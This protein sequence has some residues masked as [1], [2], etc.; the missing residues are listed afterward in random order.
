[1]DK[2]LPC[3]GYSTMAVSAGAS[4]AVADL[5][6]QITIDN[7]TGNL[8]SEFTTDGIQLACSNGSGQLLIIAT[9]TGYSAVSSNNGLTWT[10]STAAMPSVN[11]AAVT[12]D[13]ANYIAVESFGSSGGTAG[14]YSSSDGLTWT[15][16]GSIALES[17]NSVAAVGSVLVIGTSA[18]NNGGTTVP[19]ALYYST[20]GGAAWTNTGVAL[21]VVA[22][23]STEFM[24]MGS[25][26]P[27]VDAGTAYA[28]STNGSAWTTGSLP[29]G[30]SFGGSGYY[31]DPIGYGSSEFYILVTGPKVG[32]TTQY[33]AIWASTAW[34]L[35]PL[36][37][38]DSVGNVYDLMAAGANMA[39]NGKY[40][41]V[42]GASNLFY[43]SLDGVT[44]K[45]QS[46]NY[47]LDLQYIAEYVSNGDLF[48]GY[49]GTYASS[50]SIDN[51]VVQAPLMAP[52]FTCLGA[53]AGI[54]SGGHT[55]PNTLL[56][57]I[58]VVS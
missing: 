52:P 22:S 38:G 13:G 20:D 57:Y 2:Y 27:E 37:N 36:F 10:Q 3:N 7:Y 8:P 14:V 19:A 25:G 55:V 39:Y 56:Y 26:D 35:T 40:L 42:T 31:I 43:T 53:T 33:A 46:Q 58:K 12:F 29:S 17:P 16:V 41:I 24:A 23:N 15:T 9:T 44:W 6:P 32:Y 34:T 47:G 1:M 11:I 4:Q 18:W 50:L 54:V 48:F 21:A 5:M 49:G 30:Y 28:Y 45:S 51:S